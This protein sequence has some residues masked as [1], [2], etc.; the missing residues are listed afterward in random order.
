MRDRDPTQLFQLLLRG[1]ITTSREV[2]ELAGRGIGLDVVREAA[3]ALGGEVTVKTRPGAG[4]A[5]TLVVPVSTSAISA[6]HVMCGG[7]AAAIPQAVRV[8]RVAAAQLVHASS[9]T[10]L[11]YDDVMVPYAPLAVLLDADAIA[12]SSVVFVDTGSGIAAVGVDHVLGFEDTVVR[13]VPSATPID[14][15]VWGV[16]LDA[17]GH[18]IPVI[19]PRALLEATRGARPKPVTRAARPA[20]ILVVDDSLTTRM[21]E[22][23]I[24]ESA[25]FEVHVAASAE[26]GLEKLA[27]ATYALVLADVEMPGMDGFSLVAELR[28][29]PAFAELPAILV[30]SRDAPAD[31]RRGA[32]VGAQG[33]IVKSQFDQVELLA[34]IR[35]LVRA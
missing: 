19:D 32:A 2:T 31:R 8:G 10:S 23:S 14:A 17:E 6:L 33:Y 7:R 29:R 12:A 13:A 5:I 24:L 26:E 20:P 9:G 11:A 25:G 27:R 4:T 22:Q 15:I 21:L 30:T 35:R 18:P 28:A 16:A 1:G 3:E 34:M